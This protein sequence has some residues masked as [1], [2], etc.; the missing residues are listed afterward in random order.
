MNHIRTLILL[1]FYFSCFSCKTSDKSIRPY[2]SSNPLKLKVVIENVH[3]SPPGCG[4]NSFAGLYKAK[5]I[6]NSQIYSDNIL[7]YVICKEGY[8]ILDSELYVV[9]DSNLEEIKNCNVVDFSN[10][11]KIEKLKLPKYV[12]KRL[13]NF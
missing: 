4:I 10:T 6:P 5:V 11:S 1:G 12:L 8:Q 3:L 7:I 9:L 2:L 13:T